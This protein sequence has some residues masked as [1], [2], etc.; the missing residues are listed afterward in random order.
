MKSL[1]KDAFEVT[2]Q[3]LLEFCTSDSL[4][5]LDMTSMEWIYKLNY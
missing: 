2:S 5:L 1:L 3:K 4:R